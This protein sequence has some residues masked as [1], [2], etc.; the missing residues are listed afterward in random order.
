MR[1]PLSNPITR[2]LIAGCLLIA[3]G[4]S[5][6]PRVAPQPP[7]GAPDR[8][9]FIGNSLTEGNDLPAM[10]RALAEAVGYDV[11]VE[12]SLY[13]GS[14][15]EDQW[16]LT[17]ARA[18]VTN[19]D[20]DVVVLQQGPSALPESRVNLIEWTA[21]WAPVIR[22]AGGVPALYAPWPSRDRAFDFPRVSESYR[23]AAEEVGGVFLPAGDTWL[24][25]WELDPTAPLYAGDLFHPSV[26]GTYAAAVVIVARLFNVDPLRLPH[27]FTIA[28]LGTVEI[29]G[30]VANSIH[31][32]AKA[33]LTGFT[34]AIPHESVV[35]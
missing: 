24:R 2:P 1:N 10:V 21:R 16:E 34:G 31:L 32:G 9:L 20:F 6:G 17:N 13:P 8:I 26:V 30:S 18:R 19:G 23:L 15:L 4:D 29:D 5:T 22:A 14:N 35:R 3:C 7:S 28:S 11:V 33:A 27:Q 12:A 25:T